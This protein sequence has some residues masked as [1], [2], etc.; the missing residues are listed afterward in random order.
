MPNPPPSRI[1]A[2]ILHNSQEFPSSRFIP[3]Q[4]TIN[5]WV[6]LEP[7]LQTEWG[8]DSARYSVN[9]LQYYW[10]AQ[11]KGFEHGTGEDIITRVRVRHAY[12]SRQLKLDPLMPQPRLFCNCK[13]MVL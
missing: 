3:M 1:E 8:R 12:E 4:F 9:S 10:K 6:I 2:V 5:T 7:D 11:I 13:L